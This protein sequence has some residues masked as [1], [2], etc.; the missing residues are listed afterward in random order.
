MTTHRHRRLQ[1]DRTDYLKPCIG[2]GLH[3]DAPL[4]R[5]P[6]EKDKALPDTTL[7]TLI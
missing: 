5:L 7:H 1:R 6:N 2:I 3:Y 4:Q